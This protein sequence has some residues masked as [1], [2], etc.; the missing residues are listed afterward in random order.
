MYCK[1]TFKQG[2]RRLKRACKSEEIRSTDNENLPSNETIPII[3]NVNDLEKELDNMPFVIDA[4]SEV[5]MSATSPNI[6]VDEEASTSK[7]KSTTY[8]KFRV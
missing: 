1:G 8:G 6:C 7:E 5:Q 4:G 2:K 3:L